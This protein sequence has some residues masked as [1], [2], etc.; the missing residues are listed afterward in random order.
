M[1]ISLPVRR[2]TGR[3]SGEDWKL[4]GTYLIGMN[5]LSDLNLRVVVKFVSLPRGTETHL[6][7][8]LALILCS[9]CSNTINIV[10]TTTGGH[11]LN[12]FLN[13]GGSLKLAWYPP[14]MVLAFHAP[15]WLCKQTPFFTQP[16]HTPHIYFIN[17]YPDGIHPSTRR[18]LLACFGLTFSLHFLIFQHHLCHNVSLQTLIIGVES[19][20]NRSTSITVFT[21]FL[22]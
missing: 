16:H 1:W 7:G 4:I 9:N 8:L 10:L 5:S 19:I 21:C 15:P 20:S 12:Y 22:L 18:Y 3:A 14:S 11:M 17:N 13:L 6:F 2:C